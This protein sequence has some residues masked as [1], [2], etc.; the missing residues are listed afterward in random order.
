MFRQTF[1]RF[2]GPAVAAAVLL[3]AGSAW[4]QHHG[5]GG[6]G[7]GFHGGSP[8]VVGFHSGGFHPGVPHGGVP[9]G[10]VNRRGFYPGGYYPG[11]SSY[12]YSLPYEYYAPY[13]Y[14]PSYDIGVGS[15]PEPTYVESYGPVTTSDSS[16]KRAFEPPP[17]VT[18][19]AQADSTARITVRVPADAELWFQGSKMT[20][21]GSVRHFRSPPLG[22]GR[23][24]YEIRARWTENGRDITQTRAVAVSPGDHMTVEFPNRPG[25]N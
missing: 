18:P 17:P 24:R 3:M 16:N 7:L 4:A 15:D 13:S 2:R 23:Y 6:L 8:H 22:S 25:T 12:G 5:A 1:A 9:H 10:G 21:T 20:S 14:Y 19:A 11:Y